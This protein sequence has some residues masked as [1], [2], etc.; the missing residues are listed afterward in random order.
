MFPITCLTTLSVMEKEKLLI[1]DVLLVRE[2]IDRPE[3]LQQ[4]GVSGNTQKNTITDPTSLCH[5][6]KK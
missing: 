3:A 2:L 5:Y 4:I 6:F 1:L